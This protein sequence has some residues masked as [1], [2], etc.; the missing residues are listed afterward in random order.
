MPMFLEISKIGNPK[1][2]VSVVAFSFLSSSAIS[3]GAPPPL[4]DGSKTGFFV[5]SKC[6]VPSTDS[7]S[8][9]P[10]VDSSV[11]GSSSGASLASLE[12]PPGGIFPV[13]VE[14]IGGGGLFLNL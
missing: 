3:L 1:V 8:I 12:L 13:S 6:L 2:S 4:I 10:S 11:L 9:C 14:L 5:S 7:H